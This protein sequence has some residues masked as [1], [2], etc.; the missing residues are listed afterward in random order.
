MEDKS[1]LVLFLNSFPTFFSEISI[2]IPFWFFFLKK[3][4]GIFLKTEFPEKSS[5]FVFFENQTLFPLF[6][7]SFD[8]LSLIVFLQSIETNR[9]EIFL[10][11]FGK[12]VRHI[13]F[14]KLEHEVYSHPLIY[15]SQKKCKCSVFW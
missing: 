6:N 9:R 13:E 15:S 10:V 1:L 3:F 11:L 2:K 8:L 14:L 7:G 5:F 4:I 12:K